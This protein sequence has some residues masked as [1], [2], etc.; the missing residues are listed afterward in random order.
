MLFQKKNTQ[1]Q[2]EKWTNQWKTLTSVNW[3]IKRLNCPGYIVFCIVWLSLYERKDIRKQIVTDSLLVYSR[4]ENPSI[5]IAYIEISFFQLLFYACQF[6]LSFSIGFL[7]FLQVLRLISS[8]VFW[9]SIIGNSFCSTTQ[10][11]SNTVPTLQKRNVLEAKT[12]KIK[13]KERN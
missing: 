1:T 12:T 6:I 2:W 7:L 11:Q 8:V 9:I 10:E 4:F 3:N 13:Q 5:Y